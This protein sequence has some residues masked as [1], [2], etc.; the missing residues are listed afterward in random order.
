M[1]IKKLIKDI[2]ELEKKC[3]TFL[4]ITEKN[5]DEEAVQNP[6]PLQIKA[7]DAIVRECK[8]EVQEASKEKMLGVLRLLYNID[9]DN[10]DVTQ[11]SNSLENFVYQQLESS[12]SRITETHIL[13]M[14]IIVKNINFIRASIALE[15]KRILSNKKSPSKSKNT[16]LVDSFQRLSQLR[17][18]IEL[19]IENDSRELISLIIDDFYNIYIFF[20]YIIKISA[21][22]N[23][24][25][26]AMEIANYLDRYIK[27]INLIFNNR[28]LK[29]QDML[30]YYVI[31]ELS[32]LKDIVFKNIPEYNLV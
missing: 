28:H 22:K 18:K 16:K 31:H 7:F 6:N 8:E 26:L 4:T 19:Q 3:E 24:H 5:E 12:Y 20:S 1:N 23:E 30:Y 32:E 14:R 10:F 2:D 11:I 27:I 17:K 29:S 13:N 25:L 15:Q 9:T 21:T